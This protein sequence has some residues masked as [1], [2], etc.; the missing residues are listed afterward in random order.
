MSAAALIARAAAEG[1]SLSVEGGQVR[2]RAARPPADDLLAALRAERDGVLRLLSAPPPPALPAL[3]ERDAWG[4]SE[5]EKA[6]AV[7]RLFRAKRT[8]E[9]EAMDHDA[10]E[11]AA[12]AAHY[13]EEGAARPYQPGDV[14][15]LRD[16][17]HR[18]FHAHRAAWNALPAG[19]ERG[20]AFAAVRREPGACPTCAG[21]RWWCEVGEPDTARR[22]TTCHPP[23][24]LSPNAIHEVTT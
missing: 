16:G 4:L 13:A 14:D 8:A 23:D 2:V 18:G 3:P 11:R 10:A 5:A 20:R 1:V 19:P 21:R 12:R 17:L 9:P 24:H 22:C 6:E 15:P 7:A